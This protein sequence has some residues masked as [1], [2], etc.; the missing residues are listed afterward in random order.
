MKKIEFDKILEIMNYKKEN[1]ALK[2]YEYIIS[3]ENDYALV[4]GKIPLSFANVLEEKYANKYNFKINGLESKVSENAVDNDYKEEIKKYNE[5]DDDYIIKIEKAK[6]KLEL[7][8][9]KNKYIE[10]YH[11]DTKEALIIFL[12]EMKSFTINKRNF[13]TID[14]NIF[15]EILKEV[16]SQIIDKCNP[17][18]T[19]KEWLKEDRKFINTNTTGVLKRIRNGLEN[20]DKCVNPFLNK[21][22]T[23]DEDYLNKVDLSVSPYNTAVGNKRNAIELHIKDKKTNNKVSYYRTNEGFAYQLFCEIGHKKYLYFSHFYTRRGYYDNRG[24]IIEVRYYGPHLK[25]KKDL[26]YNVTKDTIGSIYGEKVKAN[27]KQRDYIYNELTNAI[28]LASLVTIKNMKNDYIRKLKIW[29]VFN[30][31]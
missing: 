30:K 21:D 17:C 29:L 11:I 27:Q 10:S 26:L 25:Y 15:D 4:K 18:I 28:K 14:Q 7:R 24:E 9:D 12:L 8:T 6:E 22:I 3:F 1:D 19:N 13:K 2:F 23:F 16:N 5:L 20:F 31:Y